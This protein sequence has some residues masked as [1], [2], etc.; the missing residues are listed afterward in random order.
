MRLVLL[1]LVV[2]EGRIVVLLHVLL[3]RSVNVH[4]GHLLL[5]LS[6]SLLLRC[7]CLGLCLCLSLSCS[8]LLLFFSL[9]LCLDALKFIEDIN[10]V[11]QSVR[12]FVP[13]CITLQ[14]SFNPSLNNGNLEKLVDIGA[15]GRVSFEHH[16][17]QV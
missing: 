14:E 12:E 15:L 13:E 7:G 8:L 3:R 6:C 2:K 16:G 1:V 17:D 9:V 10:V 5:G 11:E 4:I